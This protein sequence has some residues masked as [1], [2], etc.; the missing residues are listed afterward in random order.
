M[1]KIHF[2]SYGPYVGWL[3]RQGFNVILIPFTYIPSYSE[4]SM[5]CINEVAYALW[6]LGYDSNGNRENN[7][8]KC[9]I[10]S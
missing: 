8:H 5:T 6:G 9:I 4:T 7:T 10:F 1:L 3:S 2:L